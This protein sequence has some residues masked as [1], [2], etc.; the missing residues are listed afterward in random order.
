MKDARF[1]IPTPA[2]LAKA[3]DMLGDISMDGRDIEGR[4][5]RVHARQDRQ[6]RSQR[7]FPYAAAHHQPDGRD[8]RTHLRRTHPKSLHDAAQRKHFHHNMFHGYDFDNTMLRIG[9]MNMLLQSSAGC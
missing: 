3:V 7:A 2:L 9:S 4:P 5:L 8:D 6:R 1:T